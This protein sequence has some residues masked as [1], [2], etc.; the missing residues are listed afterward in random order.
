VHAVADFKSDMVTEEYYDQPDSNEYEYQSYGIPLT[1]SDS[2]NIPSS[3][4]VGDCS[5]PNT[6]KVAV[7]DSG[8]R[9]GHRD[10]P[11]VFYSNGKRSCAGYSFFEDDPWYR[12]IK[13]T[14]G[15]HVMGIIG[16][17][18][19]SGQYSNVGVMPTRNGICYFVYRVFSDD[20]N[21]GARWSSIY[22]S[23][24]NAVQ[25]GAKVINMSLGGPKTT[26]G[27]EYF[28]RA[29]ANGALVVAAAGNSGQVAD[30]YPASY[31][32]VLSVGAIDKNR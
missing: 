5:D 18:G 6:F 15:T 26:R 14:H 12:P 20:P 7:I 22:A 13:N 24:D 10:N 30:F 1:Q 29:Y 21:S 3:T 17:L 32:N 2:T 11:C 31:N 28:T 27:Q 8:Y 4:A 9:V 25:N 16:S 19:G 23:V